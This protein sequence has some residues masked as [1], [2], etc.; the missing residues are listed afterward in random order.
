MSSET[1][2]D[3]Q[4]VETPFGQGDEVQGVLV[5]VDIPDFGTM[6]KS[7]LKIWIETNI[8]E[9]PLQQEL[10]G[11]KVGEM[12][13]RLKAMYADD[14]DL[15][16]PA[17]TGIDPNDLLFQ[18]VKKIQALEDEAE[19]VA[20]VRTL[21]DGSSFSD[22]KIGGILAEMQAKGMQGEY[23]D[24]WAFVTAEFDIKPRKAQVL[25]QIYHACKGCG[26]TYK[27]IEKIGWSKLAVI[28]RMLTP[29][30]FQKWFELAATSTLASLEFDVKKA[31]N[32]TADPSNPNGPVD[33]GESTPIK[34]KTF[35]IHED[36]EEVI[37][38]AIEMMMAE[39]GTEFT[40]QALEK[41]CIQA[42]SL[43]SSQAPAKTNADGKIEM[44]L[45]DVIFESDDLNKVFN[46]I[47]EEHG[48]DG[49][50]LILTSLI[51]SFKSMFPKLDIE[52]YPDGNP[53]KKGEEY[54][55]AVSD[56]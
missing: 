55:E 45:D 21:Q 29:E 41:L 27:D 16:S 52:C 35:K 48:E 2:A 36:Q 19:A 10:L 7:E 51:E 32:G 47:A 30:N 1:Y 54:S 25:I 13:T 20:M 39:S 56:A 28:A 9:V 18:T 22:F 53:A 3:P 43:G 23:D 33:P 26:A 15:D 38:A 40:G 14:E 42:L 17:V 50:E 4:E 46:N 34:K 24:F 37:D 12:K 49:I 31:D 44:P 6:K 8:Q 5:N 11:C